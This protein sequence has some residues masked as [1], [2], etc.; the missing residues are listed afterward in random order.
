MS[1][2]L[3]MRVSGDSTSSLFA[4]FDIAGTSIALD[5]ATLE[6]FGF[7]DSFRKPGLQLHP[8]ISESMPRVN[9]AAARPGVRFIWGLSVST[10][11]SIC[12]AR[13]PENTT[14]V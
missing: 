14:L 10:P 11:A 2:R 6:C 12:R 4:R 9:G 5:S 7:R 13:E 8:R 3:L 1:A